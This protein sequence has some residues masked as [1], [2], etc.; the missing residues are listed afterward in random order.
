M[1]RFLLLAL[2]LAMTVTSAGQSGRAIS[3]SG[4]LY[5]TYDIGMGNGTE[6]VLIARF[7]PDAASLPHFPAVTTGEYPGPVSYI[8]LM[9]TRQ[10][11]EAVVGTDEAA[12]LM[13]DPMRIV[14][15]PAQ[16]VLQN[17]QAVVECDARTY[18]ATL[19]SV[20]PLGPYQVATR[21]NA[22]IGC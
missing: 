21:A 5:L 11:L 13:R 7:V 17:Y 20:K 6:G 16:V 8:S 22:P 1:K 4:T 10:V 18:N 3:G 9:P 19:A 12:R 2:A 15:I 14:Q